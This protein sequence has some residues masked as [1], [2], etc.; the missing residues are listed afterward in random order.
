MSSDNTYIEDQPVKFMYAGQWHDGL[1]EY[2]SLSNPSTALVRVEG[3]PQMRVN[4]K[5]IKANPVLEKDNPNIAFK[6]IKTKTHS[7][8]TIDLHRT[9][10][11]I[12]LK[13][14]ELRRITNASI[15]LCMEALEHSNGHIDSAAIYIRDIR[16]QYNGE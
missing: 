13:V 9:G 7:G 14:K 16:I 5:N 10:S 4:L 1:F 6:A 2:H 8:P 3:G 15:V 12:A 11:T